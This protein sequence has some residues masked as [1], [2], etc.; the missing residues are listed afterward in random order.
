MGEVYRARDTELDRDV[1]IK[2][3]P[4]DVSQNPDRLER[5]R[6]EAKAVA[7][8][9]HPNIL[10]IWDYGTEGDTTYAVTE[11]L[12]GETLSER[13]DRGPVGW[14][15][16]GEIGA[17]IADGLAAAHQAGIVH[18]DIKP[19]NIFLTRD[20]RVKVLDFGIA[21]S[22]PQAA[23]SDHAGTRTLTRPPTRDGML[24]GT[25]AYL[26]P[27]QV[28]GE[29][30]DGRSDIFALGC[31]LYEMV[32]GRGVFV[33]ATAVDSMSAILDEEP[34][35]LSGCGEAVP[36]ELVGAIR[37]CLEKRPEVRFQSASDLAYALR[38]LSSASAAGP[39]GLIGRVGAGWR[40]VVLG[41]A[42]V[43]VV[44]G[45]LLW[46]DP[47][48]WRSRVGAARG[49]AGS[50]SIDS[51]AVLPFVDVGGHPDT[52][53]L[54]DGIP[55]S[56]IDRL[57]KVSALRVVPRSTAFRFR[58]PDQDLKDVGRTL[59]V[60]A[61][62]SGEI[63]ARAENLVIRV[64]LVDVGGDRQLWGDRFT[65]T[66]DD[67]LS[68]EERIATRVSESL[69]VQLS[70]EERAQLARRGTSSPEAHRHYLRGRF[71]METRT[72]EGLRTAID[73]FT[74]AIEEDPGF[75]LAYCGVADGWVL[76]AEQGF[77]PL[78][79]WLPRARR[80]VEQALALDDGLA[81]AHASRALLAECEW[82]PATAEREY[83]RALELDPS[84]VEARRWWSWFLAQRGRFDEAIAE[85]RRGLEASP[86]S[87]A[88]N[89]NLAD[90]LLAAGRYDEALEQYRYALELNPGNELLLLREGMV[91][92]LQGRHG[93]AL[94]L[95]EG[96]TME[97]SWQLRYLGWAYGRAGRTDKARK[98]LAKLEAL[99]R[100]TYVDPS[101]VAVVYVGLGDKDSAFEWLEAALAART[102]R[103]MGLKVDPAW[104]EIRDDP[105]WA[106]LIGRISYFAAY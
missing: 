8:L 94:S 91:L 39:H 90:H 82:D 81:E 38:S 20:G 3:V 7:K 1:A 53:Y 62:L 6:R 102:T 43:A 22:L 25:P 32:T 80:A 31:V 78:A 33:R 21:K 61:I 17:A 86:L 88:L 23:P 16:T 72:D 4:E 67:I 44:V 96:L 27:E 84:S 51:L 29:G 9:S 28:R 40:R 19:S 47:G 66:L 98:V 64:E 13:L 55:A 87:P 34:P 75:A 83:R 79:S 26:S 49:G 57:S 11:L 52:E 5:F 12:D 2:V 60:R 46:L 56:I 54:S 103:V 45:G 41:L 76:R 95:L 105:R 35:D 63:R 89:R 10:E 50:E 69:R 15:K 37:R 70:R 106:E 77:E 74:R 92:S 58:G 101:F 42:A 99:S 18:R 65:G 68:T 93:E 59:G 48:G 30:V 24:M 14:R 97:D 85:I 36:S 104:Q 71:E 100:D 73:S